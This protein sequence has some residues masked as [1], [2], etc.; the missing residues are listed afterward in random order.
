MS[1][2]ALAPE[3]RERFREATQPALI[4]YIRES[5]DDTGDELLDLFLQEAE[6]ANSSQ[7]MD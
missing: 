3:E 7:Y 4:E 5:Q 2:N 6:I 1:V